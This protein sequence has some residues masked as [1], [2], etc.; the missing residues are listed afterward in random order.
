MQKGNETDRE[1]ADN[2]SLGRAPLFVHRKECLL[3]EKSLWTATIDNVD[4]VTIYYRILF[5]K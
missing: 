5:T 1:S 4:I 2:E 3:M